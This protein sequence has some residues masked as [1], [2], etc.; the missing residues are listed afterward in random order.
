MRRVGSFQR[1][2]SNRDRRDIAALSCRSPK[3][4][5]S[6]ITLA[7]AV[8]KETTARPIRCGRHAKCQTPRAAQTPRRR[9]RSSSISEWVPLVPPVPD[10][11]RMKN[12]ARMR[13]VLHQP[14]NQPRHEPI[15]A[16]SPRNR[17]FRL[18]PADRWS[19]AKTCC[20]IPAQQK[21][22]HSPFPLPPCFFH[23]LS[24]IRRCEL[25]APR[26]LPPPPVAPSGQSA[27]SKRHSPPAQS[28]RCRCHRRRC[29]A[30]SPFPSVFRHTV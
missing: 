16:L 19:A 30:S 9:D 17:G 7:F 26:L 12:R 14:A 25:L 28:C 11:R 2:Q 10:S 24:K 21:A 27:T 3:L 6:S 1:S 29:T 23:S 15:I 13:L 8:G 22:P 4:R 20:H 5:A 18:Q